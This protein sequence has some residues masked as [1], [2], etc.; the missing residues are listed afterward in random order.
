MKPTANRKTLDQMGATILICQAL[1][2]WTNARA[3][4]ANAQQAI[5][6]VVHEGGRG[7]LA[8]VLDGLF[9]CLSDAKGTPL[10]CGDGCTM[11]NDEYHL[12]TAV[13]G[14][15]TPSAAWLGGSISAVARAALTSSHAILRT[16]LSSRTESA[17]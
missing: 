4:Q 6:A 17:A 11:T 2:A 1:R 13:L 12:C 8:P 15:G 5:F 10:Q 14:N 16:E 9:S 3:H 7:F